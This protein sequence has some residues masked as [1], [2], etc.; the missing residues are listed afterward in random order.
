[1]LE[2]PRFF[3]LCLGTV[4][5]LR[6]SEL[7]DRAREA[8]SDSFGPEVWVMGEIHGLK[9][10]AKSG[11]VYFDLVEK[12]STGTDQYLAKVSC[13]FF[14][15]ALRAWQRSMAAV[16]IHGFELAGGIEVKLRARVDLFVREGRYQLI[17][18]EIDPSHTYGVIARRRA[19]TIEVLKA[20][21]LMDRNKRLELP[22]IPL[23]VG[24]VTSMGSAAYQDFTSIIAGSGFSFRIIL[25]DAHMQG[26]RTIREVTR[27]IRTL[28]RTPGVDVIVVTRGGGA[29]TD[30][31]VFDDIGIC[32]AVAS[33]TKPVITGIGH[34]IDLTVADLAAHSSFVTP[35]D[36]ARFL[37]SR[38][39][40]VWSFLLGASGQLGR[41]ARGSLD[42]SSRRFDLAAARLALLSK[43]F[44]AR[45]GSAIDAA[46]AAFA[47]SALAQTAD[48]GRRLLK[49]GASMMHRASSIVRGQ[50]ST[51]DRAVL[52]CRLT[53]ASM[54]SHLGHEL[55]HHQGLML[56]T[57]SAGVRDGL[58]MLERCERDLETLHPRL[59]LERGYSITLGSDGK[60]LRSASDAS[61]DDRI[62]TIL[63]QGAIHSV[64]YDKEP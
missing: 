2:N 23:G 41:T 27:G 10:H 31:F 60:A 51:L 18:S 37:V 57:L 3:L 15:G 35:T 14:Q 1:M 33:C 58:K 25:Y 63:R 39:E 61:R 54:I 21:G 29:K 30:L 64:V 9:A 45:A 47:N 22:A 13:A 11:H 24:L 34:E 46:A 55:G 6:V 62:K 43:T 12:A 19:Q 32:S 53:S 4:T 56:R 16:G 44:T 20:S 7:N 50:M 26:E 52:E 8:L 38:V 42:A 17:V 28:E 5:C 40:G 48:R 59:T 49:I 36:A